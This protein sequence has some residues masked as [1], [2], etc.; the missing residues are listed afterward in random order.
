MAYLKLHTEKCEH[1]KFIRSIFPSAS[2]CTDLEFSKM[3]KL[4][5]Y[6]HKKI[7]F[8]DSDILNGLHNN[9]HKQIPINWIKDEHL[10]PNYMGGFLNGVRWVES[11]LNSF[12]KTDERGQ[13]IK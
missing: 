2:E 8:T 12:E 11:I 1:C 10:N 6:L 3:H 13:E 5:V 4:Y 7:S 9:Y